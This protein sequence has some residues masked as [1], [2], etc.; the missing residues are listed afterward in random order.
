MSWPPTFP[1]WSAPAF[2]FSPPR[3]Q[4]RIIYDVRLYDSRLLV[5]GD[6]NNGSYE[7]VIL[8]RV[9]DEV[10]SCDREWQRVSD[11]SSDCGYGSSAAALY[12]GIK[13]CNERGML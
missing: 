1:V 13:L 10:L 6:P 2:H 12:E 8:E 9:K 11:G 4:C 5:V 3:S 7:W